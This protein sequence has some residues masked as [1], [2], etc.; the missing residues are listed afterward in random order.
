MIKDAGGGGGGV[1]GIPSKREVEGDLTTAVV[2]TEVGVVTRKDCKPRNA[3]KETHPSRDSLKG[4]WRRYRNFGL[5]AA[6]IL[7][8]RV[9]AV[10][11]H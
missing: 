7:K 2:I 10:S 6:G 9:Y 3:G 11:N 8:K 1:A 4:M 5:L